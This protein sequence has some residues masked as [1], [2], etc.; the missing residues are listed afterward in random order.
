MPGPRSLDADY[1]KIKAEA[2]KRRRKI[3]RDGRDIGSIPP[4]LSAK[5]RRECDRHLQAFCENLFPHR[6]TKPWSADHIRLINLLDRTMKEG[7]RAAFAFTR[8]RGKTTLAECAGM[9]ANM[10]GYHKYGILI[11]AT[12]TDSDDILEHIKAELSYNEEL[13]KIYPG[14]CYPFQALEGEARRAGGQL[15]HGRKT[16]IKL[17]QDEVRFPLIPGE[18]GGGAVIQTAGIEG[19]IRG[20][21][22]VLPDGRTLRPTWAVLDDLQTDESARSETQCETRRRTV[23]QAVGGL[24]E[25]GKSIAMMLPCTV[26]QP[27]DLADQ[28]LDRQQNPKWR[29]IRT[30]MMDAM[31]ENDELWER[32]RELRDESLRTREDISLATEFYRDNRAAMDKGAKPTWIHDFDP[33]EGEIS[34]IQHAMNKKL[35]DEHAF[36]AECQNEP[37]NDQGDDELEITKEQIMQRVNGL[38]RREIPDEAEYITA[39]I[40][41]QGKLL[42]HLVTAWSSSFD[43][44]LIDYGT[45]PDQRRKYF[46][47]RDAKRTLGRWKP[48]AGQEAQLYAGLREL[49]DEI[50]GREFTRSDGSPMRVNLCM[51]DANWKPSNPII[52]K[53]I[54]SSSFAQQLMPSRGR[55]YGASAQSIAEREKK[56]GERKGLN[57]FMGPAKAGQVRECVWDTNFWKSF[58]RARIAAP[59]GKPGAL[60]VFGKPGT[61]GD[62]RMLAEQ[63]TSEKRIETEGRGRRV[64]EWKL[65]KPGLDNHLLDCAVGCAVAASISGAGMDEYQSQGKRKRKRVRYSERIAQA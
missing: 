59:L 33:T 53:V 52:H 50:C 29:G 61:G 40:D 27:G 62:H 11:A 44:W 18:P 30:R 7:G 5:I 42:Y 16:H 36:W 28:L 56:R 55:F 13:G 12:G 38:G 34:A 47:L 2:A 54:R 51:I 21:R 1:S 41:V 22:V 15:H 46:T 26:I 23:E 37:L 9:W 43:G 10:A 39:F 6:F 64:D 20:R 17:A 24:A 58:F 31:P 4:I 57:W 32:Y 48:G 35:D 8:G 19:R 45:F 25:S 60:T 65:K 3:S 14:I 49:T 63:L